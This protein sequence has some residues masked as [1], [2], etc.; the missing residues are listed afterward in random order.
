M[1]RYRPVFNRCR[2]L[3]DRDEILDVSPSIA[4]QTRLFRSTDCALR[5][6]MAKQ[7]FLEHP[8]GLNK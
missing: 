7:L 1:A 4:D 3:T 8:S 2:L 6:K 5:P